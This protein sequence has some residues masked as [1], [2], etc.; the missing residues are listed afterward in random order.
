MGSARLIIISSPSGAGKTTISRALVRS[1]DRYR[2][3]ISATTR[4]KRANETEA[5]DYFFKTNQ[6]FEYMVKANEFLEYATV[7]GNSYGTPKDYISQQLVKDINVVLDIDWQGANAIRSKDDYKSLSIYILPPSMAAL[8][9][10]LESRAMDSDD[11]IASRM[12]KAKSEIQ[13]YHEYDH[14]VIN[15]NFEQTL[16]HIISVVE[17]RSEIV[18]PKHYDKFVQELLSS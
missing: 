11:V 18:P 6:Q 9:K 2:L 1:S 3:S 10:R 14:V 7:F 5:V 13:H 8:R 12:L 15:D 17:G 4:P 16:M